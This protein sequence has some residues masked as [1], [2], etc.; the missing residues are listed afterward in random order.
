MPSHEFDQ[1]LSDIIST[2]LQRLLPATATPAPTAS[3]HWHMPD[4][5]IQH[6]TY[7]DGKLMLSLYMPER[8]L[9][10]EQL[11]ALLTVSAHDWP[12]PLAASLDN[13]E[14]ARFFTQ[15]DTEELDSDLLTQ[16]MRMQQE[17]RKRWL[18]T[19]TGTTA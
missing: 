2:S 13:D 14:V 3:G 6:I 5:G 19:T 15:L 8:H 12:L 10:H 11:C 4:G 9:E 16:A 1:R 17:A 7:H 18:K